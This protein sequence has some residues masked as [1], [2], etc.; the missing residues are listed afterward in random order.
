MHSSPAP[1][2]SSTVPEKHVVSLMIQDDDNSKLIEELEAERTKLDAT[3]ME[4]QE[5]L[6]QSLMSN[7]QYPSEISTLKEKVS[8]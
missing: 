7:A 3:I 8:F 2:Q 5:Q 6:N 1:Q 4:L